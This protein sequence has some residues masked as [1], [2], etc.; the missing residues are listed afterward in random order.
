MDNVLPMGA[1]GYA[2][3]TRPST[4]R[5]RPVRGRKGKGQVTDTTLDR[6]VRRTRALLRDAV[7]VL[8]ITRDL[9][10]LT[11]Q[12][13]TRQ[14]DVNRATFYQHY[15][16]KD[17]LIEQT[18]D[19]LLTEL[20]AE[21]GPVLAGVDRLRPDVVHPSVVAVFR[22]IGR[23][24]DLYRRLIC[25]GGSGYFMR[26]FHTRHEQLCLQVLGLLS[27]PDRPSQIPAAVRARFGSSATLGLVSYWLESGQTE[28][29]E[30]IAAWYWR[31]IRPVWFEGFDE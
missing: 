11:V 24:A 26:R 31:L 2:S 21:C 3:G 9:T 25:D 22:Q 12:D 17:E 28:S 18:I 13:I 30:T 23:R 4:G 16:D 29:A 14:A 20:F 19:D 15:R 7:L 10:E 8:A 6:R 5:A 27:G 1:E